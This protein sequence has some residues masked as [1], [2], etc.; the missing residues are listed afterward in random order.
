MVL[1]SS[2][3]SPTTSFLSDIE[4]LGANAYILVTVDAISM[5]YKDIITRCYAIIFSVV[6]VLAEIDWRYVM[7]R[8]RI[9]DLWFFR[10]VFV[11]LLQIM[12]QYLCTPFSFLLGY[13][14]L[15]CFQL[16]CTSNPF[17]SWSSFDALFDRFVLFLCWFC[18][19]R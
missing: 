16:V 14:C 8:I 15:S 3:S 18:D 7:R 11:G 19:H 10:G 2:C 13:S 4:Q 6:I 5:D 1:F 12:T 17:L 9:L